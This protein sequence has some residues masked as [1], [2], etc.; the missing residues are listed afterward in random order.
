M[1]AESAFIQ[2]QESRQALENKEA[3]GYQDLAGSGDEDSEVEDNNSDP[4]AGEAVKGL[5]EWWD[6]DQ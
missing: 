5:A 6:Q 4:E 3:A 1:L 2:D